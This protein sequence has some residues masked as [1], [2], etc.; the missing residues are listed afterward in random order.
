MI[1]ASGSL[2]ELF[3]RPAGVHFF[4]LMTH[5]KSNFQEDNIFRIMQILQKQPD[6]TQRELAEQIGISLGGINFCLRA[7]T[8][9]GLIKMI[10]FAKSKNKFGYIYV[11]TPAGL[12]EKATLT[13]NFLKRKLQEYEALKDEIKNLQTEMYLKNEQK[14]L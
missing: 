8:D 11:I 9:K 14:Q 1:W 7:L 6:I 4:L 5:F 3:L 12:A 13:K 10:N 2:S